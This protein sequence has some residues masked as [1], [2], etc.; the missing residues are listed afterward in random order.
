M[1][2]EIAKKRAALNGEAYIGYPQINKNRKI[3]SGTGFLDAVV[4]APSSRNNILNPSDYS[5]MEGYEKGEPYGIAGMVVPFAGGIKGAI[6]NAMPVKTLDLAKHQFLHGTTPEAKAA[7]LASG[8]FD[9][10]PARWPSYSYSEMGAD[11]TYATPKQGWWLDPEKAAS[12]R[13]AQYK[14]AVGVDIDPSAKI[15][16]I[17]N[18]DD[19]N[20]FA[21]KMGFESGDDLYRQLGA[22]N[23]DA[24]NY[25]K[26]LTPQQY[27]Q[28]QMERIQ[29][30]KYLN[31]D[32]KP[33]DFHYQ[34]P[35]DY[36]DRINEISESQQR[37]LNEPSITGPRAA[38]QQI[39]DKGYHGVYV[40]KHNTQ[41]WKVKIPADEQLAIFD[42]SVIKPNP[43]VGYAGGGEV[44]SGL[45]A[46][47]KKIL[48]KAE[49]EANLAKF[50]ENSAVKDPMYHGTYDNFFIPKTSFG[51]DEYHKFGIHVG[52]AEQ[53]AK[54]IEDL[55][56]PGNF[57][58]I[59]DKAPSV[60]PVHIQAK[61][62]LRLD[63]NRSGRWGVNDILS[64]IMEKAD[65]GELE[66]IP[67]QHVD[68]Y[69]N[70]EFN[71]DK[72]LGKKSN[73]LWAN[74]YEWQDGEKTEAN[75][76]R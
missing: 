64:T 32:E 70:D 59:R 39:R 31:R 74:D 71:I 9:P 52:N 41:D 25:A 14:S 12:G 16:H 72:A 22:E 68:D 29:F 66:S 46:L 33:G 23:L 20:H 10:H 19:W 7:I 45:A 57:S 27:D 56:N 48:P 67:K 38:V 63:E 47:A 6:H 5:Y 8:K 76:C 53:A 51:G 3:G 49:R 11:T 28:L 26:N 2:D 21:K 44:I 43:D 30:D 62:P 18:A 42:Q 13:A 24:Y 61:N 58:R 69:F 1:T 36:A 55:N 34:T 40:D 60:M 17:R 75:V 54:R 4:G 65:R 37:A 73:R 15:A 50:L 35:D